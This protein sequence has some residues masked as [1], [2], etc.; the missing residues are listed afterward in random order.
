[1][2]FNTPVSTLIDKELFNKTFTVLAARINAKYADL[3]RKTLFQQKALFE[4][5]KIKTVIPDPDESGVP[6]SMKKRLVL[7]SEKCKIY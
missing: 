5:P 6:S 2:P 3:L 1:M 7:L 4:M